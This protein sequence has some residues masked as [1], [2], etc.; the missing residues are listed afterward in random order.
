MQGYAGALDYGIAWFKGTARNPQLIGGGFVDTPQGPRPTELLPFYGQLQ[1]ISLDAQYTV[2]S[3]LFK[4]E[5]AQREQGVL[6]QAAGQMPMLLEVD[7]ATATGGFEYTQYGLFDTAL[8]AGYLIEY[9]WDERNA[10]SDNGFQNDL[11]L[12]TRIAANDEHD[13]ALLGGV[14]IDL[15]KGSRF[16]SVEA[17]RR[18]SGS[19][20]ISIEARLFNDIAAD[21]R[22]LLP[23][24]R[25]DYL[26]VEYTHYL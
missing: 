12:A 13:S 10:R 23:I 4:L 5:A 20:K 21:D 18:L 14:V 3:W 9:L 19:S 8:D 22:V 16:F 17:S 25:D 15:D 6:V 26:Q 2:G 1:Q 11:F 24:A 7:Y